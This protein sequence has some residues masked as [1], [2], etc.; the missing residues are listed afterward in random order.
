MNKRITKSLY[1][2]VALLK[3]Y[4]KSCQSNAFIIDGKFNC[5]DEEVIE[6]VETHKIKREIEGESER[7]HIPLKLKQEI[8]LKQESRCI[9]CEKKLE[10]FYWSNSS[11][12]FVRLRIHFDHFVS[13][14]YS[15]DNHKNNLYAS[16]NICNQ[17]KSDKYF[18]DLISAKEY[19]NAKRKEKGYA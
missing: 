5:C 15:R 6:Q 1:G 17:I 4:C 9:Y 18:Y 2:S 7:S 12:K 19:I 11:S 13:W 16:C 14:K 3:G 8:L 10:G